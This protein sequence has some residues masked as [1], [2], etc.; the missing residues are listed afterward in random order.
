MIAYLPKLKA[1]TEQTLQ[2]PSKAGLWEERDSDTALAQLARSLEIPTAD[3]PIHSVPDV[4]ARAI[5]FSNAIFHKDHTLHEQFV[6]EWRGML[7]ILALRHE[8][9]QAPGSTSVSRP[10]RACTRSPARARSIISAT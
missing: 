10:R 6:G 4:W 9:H 3:N 7:A 1:G 8:F 5:L 2:L